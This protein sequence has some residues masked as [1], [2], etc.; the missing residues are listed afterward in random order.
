MPAK[1][2]LDLCGSDVELRVIEV[3]VCYLAGDGG[4][5]C[6]AGFGGGGGLRG[7]LLLRDV[8]QALLP[9]LHLLPRLVAAEA[10]L[11]LGGRVVHLLDLGLLLPDVFARLEAPE[12]RL[13]LGG[14]VREIRVV[15][16]QLLLVPLEVRLIVLLLAIV[17]ARYVG[18]HARLV[19]VVLQQPG[20]DEGQRL[21]LARAG[22]L[23]GQHCKPLDQ[24]GLQLL[25]D[26]LF[27]ARRVR[28]GQA[29]ELGVEELDLAAGGVRRV[30]AV[31]GVLGAVRAV[32]GAQAF[33]RLLLS[34]EGIRGP[35]Q[36]SP[37][38]DGVALAQ[39]HGVDG[40]ARHE[41]HQL[42]EEGLAAVLR[43]KLLRAL[44]REQKLLLHHHLEARELCEV[45]D[46]L[47]EASAHG[48]RL[49]ERERLLQRL[50]GLRAA[51]ELQPR[52]GRRIR[53]RL[54]RV[55]RH[56]GCLLR[57]RYRGRSR[58]YVGLVRRHGAP[59]RAPPR[60]L[61]AASRGLRT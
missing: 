20:R 22:L 12:A 43:V 15:Q 57:V 32:Q 49:N 52:L 51:G 24:R 6:D 31:S 60:W 42:A 59:S 54:R 45:G 46:L 61:Q 14:G 34:L 5:C 16:V 29:E 44:L 58:R 7:Y 37:V 27:A 25:G 33:G 41:R 53:G 18:H 9:G 56:G 23:L 1:A 47:R 4:I 17:G 48:V 35:H 36:R 3:N 8:C 2:R 13:D 40:A 39:D 55:A 28:D 38:L 11:D 26:V 21:V 19:G 10:R 50:G 30:R